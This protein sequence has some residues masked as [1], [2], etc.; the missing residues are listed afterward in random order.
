MNKL[1]T[2]GPVYVPSFVLEAFNKPVIHHRS[3]EFAQFYEGMLERLKYLFQAE[4]VGSMIGSGTYGVASMMYSLFQ[5]GD[6]VMVLSNGKFS[7]RWVDEGNYLGLE[8]S[9]Y[10]IEWGKAFD[11]KEVIQRA[12]DIG[13]L[14]GLIVTHSET[15]TSCLVDLEELA[16]QIREDFPEIMLMVD[17]ITSVGAMPYY[18][19]AWGIDATISASQKALMN[20]AGLVAFALSERALDKIRPTHAGDFKNIWNYMESVKKLTYPYTAPVQLLFGVNAALEKI[21]MEGL[22]A[23]WNKCHQS[24][25]T[26]RGELNESGGELFGEDQSESLTAFS[27]RDKDMESLKKE[28][29]A[30]FGWVISSGQGHLKGKILRI[31]HM[32]SSDSESM[33]AFWDDLKKLL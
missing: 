3:K 17:G 1:L 29:E 9:S 11:V 15:S 8:V 5:K 7:E 16:F 12:K 20:P 23:I 6:K 33:L 4:Q 13:N 21:E 32:G 2:P 25:K 10:Q 30:R 28:L 22:P 14:D 26:F 24:C 18:H 19:D 31:S 27:F